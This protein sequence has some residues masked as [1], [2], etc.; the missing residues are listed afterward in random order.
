M[1][2][3]LRNTTLTTLGCEFVHSLVLPSIG[4]NGGILVAWC[5]EIGPASASLVD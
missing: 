5:K 1:S 3:V 2:E 4:A